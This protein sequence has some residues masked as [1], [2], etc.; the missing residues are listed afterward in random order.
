MRNP[1][2]IIAAS[3]ALVISGCSTVQKWVGDSDCDCEV[4]E[5]CPAP[6]TDEIARAI[7][8]HQI[9]YAYERASSEGEIAAHTLDKEDDQDGARRTEELALEPIDPTLDDAALNFDDDDHRASFEESSGLQVPED[10]ELFRGTFESPDRSAVA[11]HR[12]GESI[13]LYADG[14]SV[15]SL[16]IEEFDGESIPDDAFSFPTGAIDLVRE[17]TVQLKLIH[18][19]SDEDGAVTYHLAIYKII[20]D[21]IGTIFRKPIATKTQDG[22][23]DPFG[24]LRFL[25]GVDHRI[26]EWTPLD[27]NG[28]PDGEAIR[29]EWNRWEGVYRI[30][31][32]PPTAPPD[33]Q[34]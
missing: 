18:A 1:F 3:M 24:D 21:K 23:V 13:D 30:P 33:H 20:G 27:D 26:I 34:S 32:P 11:V 16:S 5:K 12:P 31:E 25:H 22:T 10:G 29:Y 6:T 19:E 7:V 15:A 4:V 17:G 28:E 9:D 8:T 2:I 14:Q